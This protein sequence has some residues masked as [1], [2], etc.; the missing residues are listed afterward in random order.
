MAIVLARRK[1]GAAMAQGLVQALAQGLAQGLVQGL[2]R[3][4]AYR[5]RLDFMGGLAA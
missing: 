3:D 2:V 1:A 4:L 5:S